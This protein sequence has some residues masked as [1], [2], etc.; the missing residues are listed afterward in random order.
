MPIYVKDLCPQKYYV[1][2]S[3]LAG[4]MIGNGLLLGNLM[5]LGYLNE[6]I[7]DWWR[8]VFAV[9]ALICFLRQIV[10]TFIFKMESPISLLERE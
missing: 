3:V 9:P 2:F 8:V 4:F 10:I 5:G 1:R 6:D 7:E